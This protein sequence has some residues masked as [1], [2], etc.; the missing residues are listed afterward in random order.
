MIHVISAAQPA[1][2]LPAQI[3][4]FVHGK[5]ISLVI[6]VAVLVL[7]ILA[8]GKVTGGTRR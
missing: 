8:A 5:G 4:A 7:L 6:A 2:Q 1:P 3:A